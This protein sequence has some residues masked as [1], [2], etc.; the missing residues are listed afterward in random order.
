MDSM[1]MIHVSEDGLP[2]NVHAHRDNIS[3]K[4]CNSLHNLL[5]P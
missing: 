5:D 2:E 4:H 3:N 1:D